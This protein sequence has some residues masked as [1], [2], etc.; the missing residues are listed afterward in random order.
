M[1]KTMFFYT[2][3]EQINGPEG[4]TTIKEYRDAINI[5]KIIRAVLMPNNS[6]LIL[7]DDIHERVQETPNIDTRTNRVKGTTR[8]RD[9]YQT[10][11]T[12]FEEDVERFY[13]LTNIDI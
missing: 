11:V 5:S 7:L 6:L 10:E 13:K 9:V 8:K 4:E 2:R 12:L 3:K 1:N